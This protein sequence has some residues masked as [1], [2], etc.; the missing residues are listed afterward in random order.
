MEVEHRQVG[1]WVLCIFHFLLV[2]FIVFERYSN[3][4]W[5]F[6]VNMFFQTLHFLQSLHILYHIDIR[7]LFPAYVHIQIFHQK[8]FFDS[9]VCKFMLWNLNM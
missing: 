9:V 6:V 8:G 5:Y 4:H 3:I 7:I 2:I 1:A